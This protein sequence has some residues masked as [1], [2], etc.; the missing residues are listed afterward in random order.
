MKPKRKRRR[1]EDTSY[2]SPIVTMENMQVSLD[3]GITWVSA[4]NIRV[5]ASD[6]DIE[7]E[8][9]LDITNEGVKTEV[10]CDGKIIGT[11]T[12]LFF[13]TILKLE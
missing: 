8:I 11:G 6:T 7:G 9:H 12:Q 3:N 13:D 1:Y 10:V 4:T 5:I 2:W